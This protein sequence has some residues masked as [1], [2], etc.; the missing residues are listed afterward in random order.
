MRTCIHTHAHKNPLTCRN[1]ITHDTVHH[2]MP[3]HNDANTQKSQTL[4]DT[5]IYTHKHILNTD[6]H[7]GQVAGEQVDSVPL[8]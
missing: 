8:S 2:K 3:S 1:H 7:T 4:Q 6:A 5:P